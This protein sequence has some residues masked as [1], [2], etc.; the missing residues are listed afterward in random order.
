[1]GQASICLNDFCPILAR[2][3]DGG[4]TWCEQGPLWPHLRERFS[5]FGS[6]S[7]APSGEL[8]FY[9]MRTPIDV[10][11]EVAW[12]DATQGL[13]ANN[14]VWARSTDHGHTWTEPT[15]IPMPFAGSAEA[16]GPL[17][18]TRDGTWHV[19][20]APYNTFDPALVVPR[21]QVVLLS[22]SDEGKSWRHTSMMRFADELSTAAEAWV[23][24]LA[25]GRLLGTCW[26]MNQRDGSDFPNAYALSHDGGNTWSPTRSTEIMGQASALAAM[27]GGSALFVYNQRKHGEV[28]V[29]LAHVRPTDDAFNVQSNEIVWQAAAVPAS[30]GH[31][32]WT[33]FTFGEPSVTL[34]DDE[35]IL[36]SFWTLEQGVGA[37]RYV[38]LAPPRNIPAPLGLQL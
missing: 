5:I 34:L 35:S 9:G 14:L 26:N 6:V 3:A 36:I 21:N 28:G 25:D 19:C 4:V 24:E 18:V 1:M 23:V 31:G 2:S 20:Y 10:A 17:C 11:G 32:E 30:N 38:K 8:F 15:V 16:P 12:S 7:A 13:K 27:P 33:Q 29:W 37:I 22:S